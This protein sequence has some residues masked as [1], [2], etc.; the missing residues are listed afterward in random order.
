MV[1][2]QA[3]VHRFKPPEQFDFWSNILDLNQPMF[4]HRIYKFNNIIHTDGFNNAMK[5][6]RWD[7]KG[8]KCKPDNKAS[9]SDLYIEDID[10]NTFQGKRIV[11]CDPGENV[12][13]CILGVKKRIKN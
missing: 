13:Y 12:I 1:N 10:L 8:Q 4:K 2:I 7:L 6:V 3:Q 9:V 11:V 5:S